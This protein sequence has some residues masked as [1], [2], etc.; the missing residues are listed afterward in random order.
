[1]TDARRDPA[2]PTIGEAWVGPKPDGFTW[3]WTPA[4][5]RTIMTRRERKPERRRA[6]KEARRKRRKGRR[7]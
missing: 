4:P 5:D 2:E 7:E 3:D 1:M 6:T